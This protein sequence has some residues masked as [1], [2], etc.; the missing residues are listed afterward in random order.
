[1][2]VHTDCGGRV[3]KTVSGYNCDRC[4]KS[5]ALQFEYEPMTPRKKKVKKV[6]WEFYCPIY[7]M[8]VYDADHVCSTCRHKECGM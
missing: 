6:K 3:I 2:R 8:Y 5:G 1:M 7:D 4:G